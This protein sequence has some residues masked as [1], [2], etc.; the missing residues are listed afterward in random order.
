MKLERLLVPI[1]LPRWMHRAVIG[2]KRAF[3]PPKRINEGGRTMQAFRE[4]FSQFKEQS[5]LDGRFEP[6]QTDW[7]PCLSDNTPGTGFEPHYVLH[8]SWAAR[9]QIGRA[10]CRER[11]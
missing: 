3:I 4:Q 1:Y 11:V 10:S 8:T 7:F 5:C 2:F 9:V 6:H